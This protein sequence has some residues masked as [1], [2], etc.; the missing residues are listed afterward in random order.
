M[1]EQQD[2]LGNYCW[3]GKLRTWSFVEQKGDVC[4]QQVDLD[5]RSSMWM[6]NGKM[7]QHLKQL[8]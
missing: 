2:Y 4:L 5:F 1:H 3:L 6:E 7:H 8:R